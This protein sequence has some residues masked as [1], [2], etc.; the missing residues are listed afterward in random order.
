MLFQNVGKTCRVTPSIVKTF[1]CPM[2]ARAPTD[3]PPPQCYR[4]RVG[5]YMNSYQKIDLRLPRERA[6][7][8]LW[9]AQRWQIPTGTHLAHQP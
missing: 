6:M 3:V 8:L 7:R 4:E 9:I 2:K 5:G 1:H